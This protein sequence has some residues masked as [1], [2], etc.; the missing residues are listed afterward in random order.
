VV[1]PGGIDHGALAGLTDDDH[2]SYLTTGR[3][4]VVGRHPLTVGGTGAETAAGAFTNIVVPKVYDSGWFAVSL[5]TTYAKTHNLN[6]TVVLVK[7]FASDSSDGSGVVVDCENY[8]SGI[9]SAAHMIDL[10]TTIITISV[11]PNYI[12]T[13]YSGGN[14]T[15]ASGYLRVIM[16]ALA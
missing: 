16:L 14:Q 11:P 1:I 7:I 4:D 2:T 13:Y 9:G 12:T 15:L 8:D 6:T 3:H 5:S 10:T